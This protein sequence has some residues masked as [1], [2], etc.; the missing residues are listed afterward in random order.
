MNGSGVSGDPW[1]VASYSDLKLIGTGG[2]GLDDWYELVSNITFTDNSFTP[3]GSSSTPFEGQFEGNGYIIDGDGY[4]IAG[5]DNGGIFGYVSG[6]SSLNKS[7]FQNINIENLEIKGASLFDNIGVFI[8]YCYE[9]A[10]LDNIIIQDCNVNGVVNYAGGC[11]GNTYKGISLSNIQVI[12]TDVAGSNYVGGIVGQWGYYCDNVSNCKIED[13]TGSK[14]YKIFAISR[15]GGLFGRW[16]APGNSIE[17]CLNKDMWVDVNGSYAGGLIGYL[18]YGIT[19]RNNYNTGEITGAQ[20]EGTIGVGGIIGYRSDTTSDFTIEKCYNSAYLSGADYV[21]GIIG[22]A[23][24][25][26]SGTKE[27][28]YCYSLGEEIEKIVSGQPVNFGRICG[29]D[30]SPD[31]TFTNNF[32]RDDMV[33]TY[34]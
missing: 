34:N 20:S 30:D 7:Y 5:G 33:L 8:G 1:Q 16:Y 3:I 23:D 25:N 2:Y 27:I 12:D 4:Y 28:K 9:Y 26:G 31:V 15:G 22:R 13:T 21:G 10:I 19:C 6:V 11:I 24:G 29:N 17:H 18:N 14:T 32:A